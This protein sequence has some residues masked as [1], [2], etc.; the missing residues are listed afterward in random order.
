[1]NT[2]NL[3]WIAALALCAMGSAHALENAGAVKAT[4]LLKSTTSWDG[5]PLQYPAGQAEVSMLRVEIAVGGETGW[6]LHPVPNVGI[7]MQGTLEVS[8]KDG[9]TKRL[10]PGEALPEVV[11]TL[12]NGR[13]VGPDPV[14]LIVFYAGAV[15]TSLTVREADKAR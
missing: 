6:H 3:G 11:D 1:M 2:R 7:V 15:G 14:H 9:R 5:K 10:G 8:L 12:H 13:N 4:P